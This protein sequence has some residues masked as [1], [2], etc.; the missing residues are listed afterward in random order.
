MVKVDYC[1]KVVQYTVSQFRNGLEKEAGLVDLKTFLAIANIDLS[2]M[3][4]ISEHL[5]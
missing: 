5:N 1:Q 4:S 2:T 3:L